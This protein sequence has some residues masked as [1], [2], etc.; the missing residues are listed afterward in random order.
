M[1]MARLHCR[2]LPGCSAVIMEW[3]CVGLISGELVSARGKRKYGC[4]VTQTAV[5]G[6]EAGW[7]WAS[8]IEIAWFHSV[9]RRSL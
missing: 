4:S 8:H 7:A 2:G 9:T 6:V 3:G 1:G 5:R